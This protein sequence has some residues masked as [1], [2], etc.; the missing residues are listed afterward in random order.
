MSHCFV[1]A[2][3]PV[4]LHALVFTQRVTWFSPGFVLDLCLCMC[5]LQVSGSFSVFWYLFPGFR[6]SCVV[7]VCGGTRFTF[8]FGN[9]CVCGCLSM[10]MFCCGC[11]LVD[12]QRLAGSSCANTS[13]DGVRLCRAL[14][15]ACVFGW[16]PIFLQKS[17]LAFTCFSHNRL[18][19]LR[20]HACGGAAGR[21]A[22]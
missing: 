2:F 3:S 6:V 20:K 19:W 8:F 13:F 10:H 11:C 9:W 5:F 15:V 18:V 22:Q 16:W 12:I 21:A 14:A 17:L 7:R 1:W 4:F